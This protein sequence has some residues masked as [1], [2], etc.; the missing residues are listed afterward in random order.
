M[1]ILLNFFPVRAG[2]GQQVANNFIQI[3]AKEH[4]NHNWF[5]LVGEG[6]ELHISAKKEL[7]EYQ[8]FSFPYSYLARI[9]IS[10]KLKELTTAHNIDLIYN[11]AP[12]LQIPKIPQVVRSVYSNLYFPEIP[13]WSSYPFITQLKKKTIDYF[14]L[15]GTLKADG[16]VFENN[17][18]LDRASSL[19]N[20]PQ[21]RM[22]YIEPSVSSFDVRNINAEYNKLKSLEGFKILYLSSWHLNKNISVLPYVASLLKEANINVRF[23]LTLEPT[24]KEV[25]SNLLNVIHKLQVMDYFELIG[26]VK[27]IHVHQV[28][29]LS[30]AMILLSK[31]ECF[32]SNVVESYFFKKPLIIADEPWARAACERA[33]L[34]VD[35]EN[36]N[37][38]FSKI[39]DLVSDKALRHELV[40][41][42]ETR[43]LHF[44]TPE[45][46]VEKQVKFLEHIYEISKKG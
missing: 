29:K 10:K 19:Y 3:I 2:G 42:G 12:T 34:F 22:K 32:S 36:P 8:I 11:Y 37:D 33:A 31:L 16:L 25:E 39:K 43:L 24:N 1:N 30:D 13:F 27:A 41:L 17:S 28:V 26:K 35:R 46:K 40:S 7:S 45:E 14:R 6:S 20:Y 5:V 9:T 15:R 23:I 38:I 4:F 44:N 21:N 18:M